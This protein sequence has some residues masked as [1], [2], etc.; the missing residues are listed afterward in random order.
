MLSLLML[1]GLHACSFDASN[2]SSALSNDGAQPDAQ[3]PDAAPLCTGN[4]NPSIS[5]SESVITLVEGEV[6]KTYELRLNTEPCSNVTIL[7]DY[8]ANNL[9]LSESN[10]PFTPINWEQPHVISVGAVH[11]FEQEGEHAEFLQHRVVSSDQSYNNLAVAGIE[12]TIGDRAH[13]AHVSVGRSNESS[14][15]HSMGAAISDSGQYVAFTSDADNLV[16]NGN[17][18]KSD[19]FLRNLVAGTTIR[20]TEASGNG[21][22]DHS[23]KPTISSDGQSIAFFSK[24]DNLTGDSTYNEGEIFRYNVGAM[25]TTKVSQACDNCNHQIGDTTLSIAG[26]GIAVAYGT[27]RKLGN[28]GDDEYDIF[29]ANGVTTTQASLNSQD[30]S[31]TDIGFGFNAF[32]ESLSQSGRY[33]GF[34]S[35]AGTLAEPEADGRTFHVYRKDLVDRT[36]VRVSLHTGGTTPCTLQDSDTFSEYIKLSADGNIAAF[37][38]NCAFE[39]D[40]GMVNNN[41]DDIFVRDINAQSTVR[42]TVST[43]GM[44]ANGNSHMVG[45]SDDGNFIAFTSQA[46]NLVPNDGNAKRDLFVHDRSTGSTTRVSYDDRY[47]ELSDGIQNEHT[48]MSRDGKFVVFTTN[49]NILP[50]DIN[51]KRDVYRVQ[52]R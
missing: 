19:I 25:T 8:P 45:I 17:N 37:Q 28:D 14:E 11:D 6:Q 48:S 27:R 1:G 20:V 22:E 2:S 15:D 24:A 4:A 16:P 23:E 51:D 43:N 46:T 36:L 47:R 31:G 18:S 5:V 13:L 29:I 41:N 26:N 39:I 49:S 52:M 21:G 3:L 38:S 34:S 44:D 42:I 33:L 50:S 32:D 40:N 30:Q 12:V 7:V 9:M 35:A 10:I